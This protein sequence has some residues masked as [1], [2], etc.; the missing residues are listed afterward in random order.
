MSI[1]ECSLR[2]F[3]EP[4]NAKIVENVCA[5][6]SNGLIGTYFG[7]TVTNYYISTHFLIILYIIKTME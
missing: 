7:E 4:E 6:I 5:Q 1:I 3:F 2:G